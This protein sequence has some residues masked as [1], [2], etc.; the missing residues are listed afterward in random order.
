MDEYVG[1]YRFDRRPDHNVSIVREG[2]TIVS[3]SS[4]QR[5]VLVSLS[6]HSLLTTNYDGE[7]RFRRDRRGRVS[8]F[9]YSEFGKRMGIARESQQ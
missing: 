2:E 3:E 8:H 5:R 6:E 9:V 4:G 7:G 1:E